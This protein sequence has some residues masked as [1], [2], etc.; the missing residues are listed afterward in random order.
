MAGQSTEKSIQFSLMKLTK[1]LEKWTPAE[2]RAGEGWGE[3]SE[4]SMRCSPIYDLGI[5][6][7]FL[8][9]SMCLLFFQ[10]GSLAGSRKTKSSEKVKHLT[11]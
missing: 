9:P 1:I 7:I 10:I 6:P 11:A 3:L 4:A 8:V 2:K 5:W